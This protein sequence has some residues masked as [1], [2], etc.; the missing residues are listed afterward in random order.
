M[1]TAQEMPGGFAL[2][3]PYLMPGRVARTVGKTP[4]PFSAPT[5]GTTKGTIAGVPKGMGSIKPTIGDSSVSVKQGM[6]T[7]QAKMKNFFGGGQV[8]KPRMRIKTKPRDPMTVRYASAGPTIEEAEAA[9]LGTPD[10]QSAFLSKEG[11]FSRILQTADTLAILR[12]ST[13]PMDKLAAL[14]E[15]AEL[16]KEAAIGSFLRG[17]AGAA[18]GIGRTIGLRRGLMGAGIAAGGY[19][20]HRIISGAGKKIEEASKMREKRQAEQFAPFPSNP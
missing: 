17:L 20:A 11:S 13:D 19:G 15:L 8:V 4:P 2:S 7:P 18:G 6:E 9:L 14:L 3:A 5:V 10:V 1:K 16:R 12:E